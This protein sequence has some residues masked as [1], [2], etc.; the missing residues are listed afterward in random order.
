MEFV[1]GGQLDAFLDARPMSTRRAAELFVK[2]AR[3]VQF[4][5][6]HGILH[7]DIKPGNILLDETWRTAPD[8]LR[9]CAFDR[10]GEHG[11]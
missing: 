3:T 1:E 5:H 11:H 4:A 9:P 8:R 7:R 10:T 2:I 6:E